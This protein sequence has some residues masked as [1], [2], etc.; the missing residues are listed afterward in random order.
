MYH[1]A[2]RPFHSCITM[3]G[4]HSIVVSRCTA[5][6]P[7]VALILENDGTKLLRNAGIH[8]ATRRH[9]PQEMNLHYPCA[10]LL[11]SRVEADTHSE[12]GSVSWIAVPIARVAATS[13]QTPSSLSSVCIE[14]Y[15]EEREIAGRKGSCRTSVA[16][17]CVSETNT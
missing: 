4:V 11:K 12:Y 10:C 7:L 9:I 15:I 5:S 1:D 3:H 16:D 2:R 8:T 14:R 13:P 6:I 17:G